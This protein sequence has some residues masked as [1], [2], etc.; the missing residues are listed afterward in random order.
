MLLWLLI[1]LMCT[2]GKMH[3][4]SSVTLIDSTV[5]PLNSGTSRLLT[6]WWPH[7][8]L[9]CSHC[10]PT[11]TLCF[12]NTSLIDTCSSN[13]P[14][15]FNPHLRICLLILER[16]EGREREKHQSVASHSAWTR[17]QTY[18]LGMCPDQESNPHTFGVWD[19]PTNWATWPGRKPPSWVLFLCTLS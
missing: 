17:N 7:P 9:L 1:L 8:T 13:L 19:T 2:H 10:F 6:V 16:E 4:S 14:L 18:N 15:F 11:E 12:E 3:W 5:S